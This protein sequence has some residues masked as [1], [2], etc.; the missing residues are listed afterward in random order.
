[1]LLP[2]IETGNDKKLR[3]EMNHILQVEHS[4]QS[5]MFVN[6]VKASG[7][8]SQ[9]VYSYILLHSQN[10]KPPE[11]R[12]SHLQSGSYPTFRAIG[13]A[14][15]CRLMP[16]SSCHASCHA[17]CPCLMPMPMNIRHPPCSSP[18]HA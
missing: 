1:M 11:A 15:D 5:S 13:T 2:S 17:S 9:L 16:R 14:T 7:I 8:T 6:G 4:K 18:T 10:V 3:R 12:L